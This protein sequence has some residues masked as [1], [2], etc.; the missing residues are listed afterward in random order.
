MHSHT[1]TTE[2]IKITKRTKTLGTYRN[3]SKAVKKI[4][5]DKGIIVKALL[6][7]NATAQQRANKK[8]NSL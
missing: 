1:H 6:Q 3:A 2:V 8:F 4:Q 5:C 7:S